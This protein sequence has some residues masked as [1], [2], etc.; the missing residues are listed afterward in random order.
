MVVYVCIVESYLLYTENCFEKMRRDFQE[1]TY[2]RPVRE[3]LVSLFKLKTHRKYISKII[4][5]KILSIRRMAK[6]DL[7][8]AFEIFVEISELI[9]KEDDPMAEAQIKKLSHDFYQILPFYHGNYRALL[10]Q[11][12]ILI[13]DVVLDDVT[14]LKEKINVLESLNALRVLLNVITV[15]QFNC[16]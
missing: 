9:A 2:E 1:C 8:R 15:S 10:S 16:L 6:R 13:I 4:N 5:T 7:R 3:L 12:L 14:K 11:T